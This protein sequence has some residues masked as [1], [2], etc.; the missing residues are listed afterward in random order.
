M[1]FSEYICGPITNKITPEKAPVVNKFII[2]FRK[3][4]KLLGQKF[5]GQVKNQSI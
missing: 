3:N 4:Q 1:K 2:L 5:G